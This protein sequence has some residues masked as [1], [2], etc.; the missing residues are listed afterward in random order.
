MHDRRWA[1]EVLSWRHNGARRMR[2]WDEENGVFVALDDYYENITFLESAAPG[3]PV[4]APRYAI[5]R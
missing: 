3:Q 5:P 2:E 1:V 4:A